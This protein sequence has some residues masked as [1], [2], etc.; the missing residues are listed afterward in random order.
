MR[1]SFV[2]MQGSIV[3]YTGLSC[4]DTGRFFDYTGLS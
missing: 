3:E 2:Q 4:A 1:G